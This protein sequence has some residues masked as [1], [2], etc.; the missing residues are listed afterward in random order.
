LPVRTT[1]V[2]RQ[3]GQAV[4]KTVRFHVAA[5]FAGPWQASGNLIAAA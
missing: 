4:H 3:G 2:L 5:R 1:A